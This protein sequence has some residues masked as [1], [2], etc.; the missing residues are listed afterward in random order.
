MNTTVELYRRSRPSLRE[1]FSRLALCFADPGRA[2][3]AALEKRFNAL[4]EGH[5]SLI[6]KICFGY[7]R[8]QSEFDDLYQDAL[9]NIW[10]GLPS[11]RGDASP[12]TW[13]YRVTL[14]TCVSTLRKRLKEPVSVGIESLSEVIDNDDERKMQ[15]MELH[16]RIAM[17]SGVDKAMVMMWLDE[18][19]YDEIAALTGMARNTVATRLRRAKEKIKQIE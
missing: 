13:I 8:T 6:M 1:W 7:A 4:V 18:Y 11:F 19:S 5:S 2:D 17:L 3:R 15:L 9:I 10:Q 14:N 16:R 12:K